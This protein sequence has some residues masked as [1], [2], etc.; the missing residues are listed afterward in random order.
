MGVLN[1]ERCKKLDPTLQSDLRLGCNTNKKVK[2][3]TN[4]KRRG[5]SKTI[6]GEIPTIDFTLFIIFC[7]ENRRLK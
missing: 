6:V 2:R 4:K 7:C 5:K 1:E 3:K